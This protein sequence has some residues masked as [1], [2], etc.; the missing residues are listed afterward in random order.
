MSTPLVAVISSMFLRSL[1]FQ[2]S[3]RRLPHI[4]RI[5]MVVLVVGVFELGYEGLGRILKMGVGCF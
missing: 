3:L 2:D 4:P 1:R 5:F